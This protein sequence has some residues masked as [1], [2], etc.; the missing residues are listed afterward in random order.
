[1][2]GPVERIFQVV[3]PCFDEGVT[4]GTSHVFLLVE[5][6]RHPKHG[7]PS[8]SLCPCL[9]SHVL[10]R[11]HHPC[12]LSIV[13]HA[14]LQEVVESAAEI[15]YGLIHARYILTS[16]GMQ[17][18]VS[19]WQSSGTVAGRVGSSVLRLVDG[20][21]ECI[22]SRTHITLFHPWCFFVSNPVLL[23]CVCFLSVA[24]PVR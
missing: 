22:V 10:Q 21:I 18:M 12:P 8:L 2:C 9:L 3:H 16:R 11:L 19:T 17:G 23:F 6:S 20:L 4:W 14:P 13:C 1:M 7:C 5:V 15:L 24:S